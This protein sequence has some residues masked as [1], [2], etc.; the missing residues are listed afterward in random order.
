MLSKLSIKNYKSILDQT[1]ELGRVNVFIGE[2]GCGKTNILEALAM[3]CAAKSRTLDNESLYNRGVRV[4]KPSLTFSS[5]QDAAQVPEI[6]LVADGVEVGEPFEKKF[7]ARLQADLA[8]SIFARWTDAVTE[9]LDRIATEDLNAALAADLREHKILAEFLTRYGRGKTVDL[10]MSLSD[11]GFSP[12]L[13]GFSI[14]NLTTPAL[15]GIQI[16]SR[17]EPLGIHG[18]GLDIL[19]ASLSDE[20][21]EQLHRYSHFISWLDEVILDQ[22]DQRKFAGHKLGKS[23]SRLYFRDRFMATTNNVFSA[24]N[25]NEGVLHAL[26]YL[27]LFISKRTPSLFAIDNIEQALNPQLCRALMKELAQLAAANDKQA[28]ITTHNPAI[29]DGMNLQDDQ[30]RLF[31]V[32]RSDEGDTRVRRVKQKDPQEVAGR[33]L[34][35]SELWMRGFLGGI[36]KGF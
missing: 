9:Q 25:A 14:Y 8:E 21:R 5:F 27:T 28:L 2:N 32:Y 17:R 36:P 24:E 10:L 34:K 30:Q 6:L 1:I 20:E 18:E 31:V 11:L 26:C 19:I 16:E 23:T 4:A 7:R 35:L 22:G 15:R 33:A 3:L 13:D 12:L 29:L